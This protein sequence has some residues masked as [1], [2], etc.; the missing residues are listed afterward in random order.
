MKKSELNPLIQKLLDIIEK[1]IEKEGE[2][3]IENVN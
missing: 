3:E 2:L 1:N